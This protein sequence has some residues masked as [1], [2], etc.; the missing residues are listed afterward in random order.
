MILSVSIFR[1]GL[2]LTVHEQ[3]FSRARLVYF[4]YA[5][6]FRGKL[7]FTLSFE[8]TE[9]GGLQLRVFHDGKTQGWSLR[10]PVEHWESSY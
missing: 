3:D 10:G 7:T 1:R 8:S 5:R 9:Q 6:S 4:Q 2:C